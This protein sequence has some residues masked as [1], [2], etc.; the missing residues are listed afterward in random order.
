MATNPRAA[1][2]PV[3]VSRLKTNGAKIVDEVRST[4]V[5]VVVTRRGRP[6]AAIQPVSDAQGEDLLYRAAIHSLPSRA[7]LDA[8]SRQ[9]ADVDPVYAA[10]VR[11]IPGRERL[12][13][14]MESR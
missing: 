5:P 10:Y 7:Q 4:G 13:S 8:I 9:Y 12:V 2:S 14:E 3:P 1:L 11:L 6:V